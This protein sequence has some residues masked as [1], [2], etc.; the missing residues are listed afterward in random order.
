MKIIQIAND[1]D[2]KYITRNILEGLFLRTDGKHHPETFGKLLP[3]AAGLR[4]MR[5]RYDKSFGR[6]TGLLPLSGCL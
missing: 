6:R 1:E 4:T 2:K 3:Q 5:W